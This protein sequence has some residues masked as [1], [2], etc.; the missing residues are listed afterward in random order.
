MILKL[1]AFILNEMERISFTRELLITY[2]DGIDI[3]SSAL[4]DEQPSV[5]ADSAEK[6]ISTYPVA[7]KIA[8]PLTRWSCREDSAVCDRSHVT[9]KESC[10][11][12]NNEDV[13]DIDG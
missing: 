11:R 3:E 2:G 5:R 10:V 9:F 4:S 13:I 12:L 8:L 6:A 1:C 7:G